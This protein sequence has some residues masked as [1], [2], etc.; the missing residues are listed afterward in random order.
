MD[1]RERNDRDAP[2]ART[3]LTGI[4]VN[5]GFGRAF[6]LVLLLAASVGTVRSQSLESQRFAVYFKDKANN[7][8]SVYNPSAFLSPRA[9]DRRTNQNIAV[10]ENDLP[11]TQ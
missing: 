4:F 2:P 10:E 3:Q 7:A 1:T 9:V 11:V 5:M 6:A 8:Y